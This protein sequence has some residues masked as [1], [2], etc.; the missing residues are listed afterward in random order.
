VLVIEYGDV[1]YAP[2]VFDPPQIIWGGPGTTGTGWNLFSTPSPALNNNTAQVVAGRAVGGSS[3]INGMVFD[4]GSRFDYDGWAQLQAK[5]S[6]ADRKGTIDWSWDALYPFFK[7]SVT[8]TPPPEAVVQKLNY[9]WEADAFD[10]T[11]PIHASFPEFQWGDHFVPR[12][13]WREMGIR[14]A[15]KCYSGDKD[16]LCWIATSEHPV[17]ARRS[18]SGLGHYADVVANRPNYHLLVKHR[19]Y[20]QLPRLFPFGNA[21]TAKQRSPGCCIRLASPNLDRQWWKYGQSME[22]TYSPSR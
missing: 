21:D 6:S 14:I 20:S 9:T 3:A 2:G 12:K 5:S 19:M 16:G 11:T 1:G 4:R 13:A 8:F 15:D 17:T 10:N 7:K 22:P 18:Y